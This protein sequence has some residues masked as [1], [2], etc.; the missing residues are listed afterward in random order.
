MTTVSELT[1]VPYSGNY[2]IDSLLGNLGANWNYLLPAQSTLCYTF[3]CS[4]A[5]CRT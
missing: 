3:D 4:L 1:D 2:R 5:A